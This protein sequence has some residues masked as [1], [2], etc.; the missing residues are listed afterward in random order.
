MITAI[1]P[2]SI[3]FDFAFAQSEFYGDDDTSE[4]PSAITRLDVDYGFGVPG[5]RHLIH[6]NGNTVDANGVVTEAQGPELQGDF[7]VLLEPERTNLIPAIPSGLSGGALTE[8]TTDV[9]NPIGTR[10]GVYRI[11]KQAADDYR[12]IGSITDSGHTKSIWAKVA[13]GSAT[14]NLM[15]YNAAGAVFTLTDE[16]QRFYIEDDQYNGAG[17]NNFYLADF[18]GGVTATEVLVWNPSTFD[19]GGP[20]TS[21]VLGG[22][23]RTADGPLR[24]PNVPPSAHPYVEHIDDNGNRKTVTGLESELCTYDAVTETLTVGY[25]TSKTRRIVSVSYDG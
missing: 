4:K 6:E 22:V 23:T 1:T 12:A 9:L 19:D 13:S 7:P 16:W 2:A 3:T 21:E 11:T 10:E 17:K 15:D 24:F 14:V 20:V 18:R 8:E 25:D 5:V